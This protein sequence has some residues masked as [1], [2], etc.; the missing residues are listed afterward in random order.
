M[1]EKNKEKPVHLTKEGLEKLQ[2]EFNERTCAARYR[3]VWKRP[4]SRA[5]CLKTPNTTMPKKRSG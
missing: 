1:S 4:E 2:N 3:T 5:T